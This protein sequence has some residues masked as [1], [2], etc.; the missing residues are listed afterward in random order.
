MKYFKRCISICL[1]ILSVCI[2]IVVI[3][4]CPPNI[5]HLTDSDNTRFNKL[6]SKVNSLSLSTPAQ[7]ITQHKTYVT[8]P[9]LTNTGLHYASGPLSNAGSSMIMSRSASKSP[10]LP[11]TMTTK[12]SFIKSQHTWYYDKNGN[13][14]NKWDSIHNQQGSCLYK[15]E[16][17][18]KC[19]DSKYKTSKT[20][21]DNKKT[22]YEMVGLTKNH[23]KC[24][25]WTWDSHGRITHNKKGHSGNNTKEC[26]IPL[27]VTTVDNKTENIIVGVE[28][29]GDHNVLEKQL[30]SFY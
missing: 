15:N 14:R 1:L 18:G 20:C 24:G 11:P 19:S 26:L 9:A 2:L 7:L 8:P 6:E 25:V 23:S 30:W 27:K 13:I 10:N 16:S 21:V 4:I 28:T 5:E 29:C 12:P 3:K 22:W 17:P